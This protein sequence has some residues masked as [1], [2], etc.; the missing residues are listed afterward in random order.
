MISQIMLDIINHDNLSVS[1]LDRLKIVNELFDEFVGFGPIDKLI[2]DP[3]VTEIMINGP[4]KV[5]IEKH[6]K[7]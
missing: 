2:K 3:E 5:Y 6:G 1:D 7:K 4:K